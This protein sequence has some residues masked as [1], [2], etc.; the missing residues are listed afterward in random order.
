MNSTSR[1]SR[2]VSSAA[3]SPALAITGPEVARKSDAQF[4]RHDLRQ[5]RLAE[6]RR[7]DEQHMI[8]RLAALAGGL[9]EH[10]QIGARLRL[11]DEFGQFLRTQRGVADIV[12][13]AFRRDQA[14]G[15]RS[16][17]GAIVATMQ[18]AARTTSTGWPRSI[19]T[20][21]SDQADSHSACDS[22]CTPGKITRSRASEG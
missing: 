17:H 4:A 1:S 3:R 13:A 5:R 20:S 21:P 11:A 9:D 2:L 12:G 14:I 16:H 6:A 19:G 7:P 22:D 18:A 8:E 10:L 15:R